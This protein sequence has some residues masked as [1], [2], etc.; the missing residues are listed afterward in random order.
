[1][2]RSLSHSKTLQ[3]LVRLKRIIENCLE[4]KN[5]RLKTLQ[6][7][8]LK[9]IIENS[10]EKKN[11]RLKTQQLLIRFKRIIENSLEKK[12]K[13]VKTLQLLVR[14]KRIVREKSPR[15]EEQELKQKIYT[16]LT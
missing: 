11:I 9:R 4:K 14:L 13:G 12:N 16:W 6:L 8:N 2:H 15:E 3:F 1:M 5:K 7:H 10:L